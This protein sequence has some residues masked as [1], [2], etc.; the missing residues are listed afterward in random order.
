M[1]HICI[2]ILAMIIL[3]TE[4]RAQDKTPVNM[5]LQ[6]CIDY[7]MKHNYTVKNAQLDVLIQ[8]AQNDQTISLSL[9][10]VNGSGHFNYFINPQKSF[11]DV[12]G[13]DPT[14]HTP[15]QV[16]AFPFSLTYA[17]DLSATGSQ[18]L[19]DGSV[20]IALQARTALIELAKQKGAVSEVAVR[21]NII[22]SYYATIVAYNQLDI[23]SR[24]LTYA[25]SM[26]HDLEV[27]Q[28]N[29]FAET[30]DVERTAVQ[31]NN[32]A[33]DSIK[34]ANLASLSEQVLKYQMGMDINTPIKLT[35]NNLD[36]HVE[37]SIKLINDVAPYTN[38]PEYNLT[39]TGLH[40]NEYNLKRY[41]MA[42]VPTIA[43]VGSYG[44]NYGQNRFS[45]MFDF[46]KYKDFSLVGLQMSVPIFN[47]FKRTK[48][49]EEAKLNI[50]KA[51]NDLSNIKLTID[52]QTTQAKT[53]LKN[54][55]LQLQSQKRNVALAEDV[56]DLAQK[57]YKAG[58]GSNLEV[59]TAQ[60]DELKV[61]NSYFSTLLDIINAEADLKKALGQL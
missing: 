38:V 47:G 19:F 33:A 7:A 50:E 54:A 48:Q 56:L 44:W 59:T 61:Q 2:A 24:S 41:K 60:T 9:P 42:A 51:Q 22:K 53:S 14:G 1:R 17:A 5:S 26:Q 39:L 21:Y 3:K 57:K 31:V 55:L 52:F 16:Q 4:A 36:V 27:T 49:V 58:V 45:S 46:G 40:L 15:S 25:R 30:I 8:K 37:S 11:I 43:A 12:A 18:I 34:V 28:K 10:Q 29:G 32:L 35:D 23:L 20:L 6:D 13:F